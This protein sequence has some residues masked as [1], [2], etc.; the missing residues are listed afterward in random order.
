MKKYLI[1]VLGIFYLLLAS[2]SFAEHQSGCNCLNALRGYNKIYKNAW[3]GPCS[4]KSPSY[5]YYLM[6]ASIKLKKISDP[7]HYFE[8]YHNLQV[9]NESSLNYLNYKMNDCET[10]PTIYGKNADKYRNDHLEALE[11]NDEA[12]QYV[13]NRARMVYQNCYQ[14]KHLNPMTLYDNSFLEF[15]EGNAIE[16][17]ELAEKYISVCKER[18]IDHQSSSAELMILDSLT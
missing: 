17:A 1:S 10:Y 7:L 11:A 18:N 12:D 9:F 4:E 13:R 15:I 6:S 16:S 5:P 14:L 2:N 3:I 8:Y